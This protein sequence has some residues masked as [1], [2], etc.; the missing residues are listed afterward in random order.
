[1]LRTTKRAAKYAVILAGD[2]AHLLGAANHIEAH[3]SAGL[4]TALLATS[5]VD[6][7]KVR[8]AL[9]RRTNDV[10][11]KIATSGKVE[12][13][14]RGESVETSLLVLFWPANA[15]APLNVIAD[16]VVVVGSGKEGL[17]EIAEELQNLTPAFDRDNI[18]W[19]PESSDARRALKH[20]A[21][22]MRVYKEDWPHLVETEWWSEP[23]GQD[24]NVQ[25]IVGGLAAVSPGS[26]VSYSESLS[27]MASDQSCNVRC[28]L[29]NGGEHSPWG[30]DD[31]RLAVFR[32][33]EMSVER[34]VSR[35]NFLVAASGGPIKREQ[36]RAILL[37]LARG[38]PVFVPPK[39]LGQFRDAVIACAPDQWSAQIEHLSNNAG[40]FREQ[41]QRG[42]KFVRKKYGAENYLAWLN[43]AAGLSP[44]GSKAGDVRSKDRSTAEQESA[45][46][47]IL[48]LPSNGV[49]LGHLSRLMAIAKRCPSDIRV[50]FATMVPA[51][52]IVEEA[53]WICEYINAPSKTNDTYEHWNAYL[54]RELAGLIRFYSPQVIV[55]DGNAMP[56]GLIKVLRAQTGIGLVWVRN[57]MWGNWAQ[58]S[59][60]HYMSEQK[61][62]DLVI[63][64]GDL[65][66]AKDDGVTATHWNRVPQP[67]AFEFVPPITLVK[68][69]EALSR[70]QAR[71]RLG[72]RKKRAVLITLGAGTLVEKYDTLDVI[73]GQIRRLKD[74]DIVVA[75]HP[76]SEWGGNIWPNVLTV[77][78]FPLSAY[79]LAFDAAV[80]EAGYNTFHDLMNFGIPTI[81]IPH[82]H[83]MSDRQQERSEWAQE[84]GLA[85][86]ISARN[87]DK[88]D[89]HVQDMIDCGIRRKPD[90]TGTRL[91]GGAERAANLVDELARTFARPS[92]SAA[93]NNADPE[94]S[95]ETAAPMD[96]QL[97]L[98][99][100]L[101][102]KDAELQHLRR[103]VEGLAR[104][105]RV[106]EERS[107]SGSRAG[108]SRAAAP[109][110]P[111]L[112]Q[113]KNRLR[114]VEAD[115]GQ[116]LGVF[117]HVDSRVSGS[118]P[119]RPRPGIRSYQLAG[120]EMPVV[121]VAVFG[122]S[123]EVL[124]GIVASVSRL[125][126]EGA[127]FI[128]VFLTDLKRCSAI[129]KEGYV[130]EYFRPGVFGGRTR[131]ETESRTYLQDKLRFALTKWGISD[132][133]CFGRT[134]YP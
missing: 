106:L 20:S 15:D 73:I 10:A 91:P 64:A 124:V 11:T 130:F 79:L 99:N 52:H 32:R 8:Q 115:L 23:N 7:G 60:L 132:V 21:G 80:A 66:S 53:G 22:G 125:Q 37:A 104:R 70:K 133:L 111:R 42:R 39:S 103:L 77:Q 47:T 95:D 107:E 74:V 45:Q 44:V 120:K 131:S 88:L 3:A 5:P 34:F 62:C 35:I 67:G 4:A 41:A 97:R 72:I 55:Y 87:P 134:S 85:L 13:C 57:G 56:E 102:E 101:A 46:P 9:D 12:V 122:E 18:L 6:E 27:Q 110:V 93:N 25:R 89:R 116:D 61:H 16:R 38:V 17:G 96:R 14:G 69:E 81:F 36:E 65:A 119:L 78:V 48:F 59:A 127:D 43:T 51:V 1:M 129:T 33:S 117:F 19:M 24:N 123:E 40:A 75:R 49:G 63:E 83:E 30:I 126:R 28:L 113:Q 26:D 54:R 90:D 128:P 105:V 118:G 84:H 71:K 2:A 68:P 82:E 29:E 112:I 121:G 50:V 76:L 58:R 86:S 100:L 98:Q 114:D 109:T 108:G 94:P 92:R 31:N